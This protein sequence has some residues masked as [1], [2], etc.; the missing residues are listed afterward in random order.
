VK[1][2]ARLAL[3]V[4]V[5][6]LLSFVPSFAGECTVDD[7]CMTY[8]EVNSSGV[9]VN[10]IVCQP[11]VCTVEWGGKNPNT[12]NKLVPQV[13]ADSNGNHRSGV[14]P[15]PNSGVTLSESNGTFT[16]T[17]NNEN[18]QT[19]TTVV[20]SENSVNTITVSTTTANGGAT[21]FR[22]EDTVKT[23]AENP[24]NF[25]KK[26]FDSATPATV[27]AVST[28]V[29]KTTGET[30]ST[31]EVAKTF[32]ETTTEEVFE[33]TMLNDE[34]WNIF[35]LNVILNALSLWT[36]MLQDWFISFSF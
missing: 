11:S 16:L 31:T 22:Y 20:E 5:Y 4:L 12:G 2:V 36:F 34:Y 21:S 27:T 17:N 28:D 13:A 3:G 33:N 30:I 35:E 24:V 6:S 10:T 14:L 7:P 29:N 8:A 26:V 32:E 15:N 23:S 19:Q 18:V 9:V 25:A 1:K